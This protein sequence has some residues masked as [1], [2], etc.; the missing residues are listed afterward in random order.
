MS[1][2]P[3]PEVL[4]EGYELA[5]APRVDA[6][7]SVFFTDVLG[8]GVHRWT[9]GTV[10]TVLAKRRGV[11]GLALHADG[12]FVMSGREVVH[13]QTGGDQRVLWAPPDDVT[14]INDICALSD[15]TV[16]AG[17]LR[18]R[19]FAGDEVVPGGFWRIDAVG[20]ATLIADDIAWPNGCGVAAG[21]DIVYLCDYSRGH[22]H[23]VEAATGARRWC[24]E[25]PE[26]EADGLAVDHEGGA[27]VAQPRAHRLVRL[28]PDGEV[29]RTRDVDPWFVTSL[30]LDGDAMY[31]TT[32]R[33]PEAPGALLRLPAPVPGPRHL[34]ATI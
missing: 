21:G 20:E 6:A 32:A 1:G 8:G 34:L 33:T 22:V 7:G 17:A 9:D 4:A 15:G 14:G 30:G 16:V 31:L 5:E 10:E 2:G 25:L 12:G 13:V 24:A 28:T 3:D 18:F 29:E 27:W 23:A 11:G 26:G 19:P